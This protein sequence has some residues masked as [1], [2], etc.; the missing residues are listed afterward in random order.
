[1]AARVKLDTEAVLK[2][3]ADEPEKI[4]K[5][6][7]E[8]LEGIRHL[9][10]NS[11]NPIRDGILARDRDARNQVFFECFERL[12]TILTRGRGGGGSGG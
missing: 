4:T 6:W 2:C 5:R 9:K 1:M 10:T 7:L 11:G 3:D 8:M 12:E